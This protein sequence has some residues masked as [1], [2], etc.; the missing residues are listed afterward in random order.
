M[1]HTLKHSN[2]LEFLGISRDLGPSPALVSPLCNEGQITQYL[3]NKPT[4]NRP[5]LVRVEIP[6][7]NHDI[8]LSLDLPDS[9][10]TRVLTFEGYNSRRSK[11]C[12]PFILINYQMGTL[13]KAFRIM[14]SLMIKVVLF[15]VTSVVRGS[16]IML[17]SRLSSRVHHDTWHQSYLALK[18]MKR[19][20][21]IRHPLHQLLPRRQMYMDLE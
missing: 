19:K 12:K 17:V 15:S 1:W 2:T 21:R 11:M 6:T 9:K 14:F 13:N 16:S 5:Q 8:S 18:R 4:A 10:R 7:A 20:I 3:Q